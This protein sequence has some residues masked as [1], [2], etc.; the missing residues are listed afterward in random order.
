MLDL[1]GWEA[2]MSTIAA[3]LLVFGAVLI[4]IVSYLVG[5]VKAW[6]QPVLV[7]IAAL[8]GG[9]IGSESLG[10]ASTWGYAFEDLNVWPAVIGALLLGAIT[11]AFI[12]YFTGGAYVHHAQPI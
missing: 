2:G 7:A 1:F 3:V 10:T 9:Y 4:G 8:I 6:W 12:R 11:D 5:E